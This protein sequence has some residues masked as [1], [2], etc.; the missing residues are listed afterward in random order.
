MIT[1]T[2]FNLHSPNKQK[3][4]EILWDF[5]FHIIDTNNYYAMKAAYA[6]ASIRPSSSAASLTAILI[7]QPSP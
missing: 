4:S 3:K 5:A 6:S 1:I 7:I 2:T